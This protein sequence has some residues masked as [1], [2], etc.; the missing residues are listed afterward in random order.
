[1][2]A[3]LNSIPPSIWVAIIGLIAAV[4][5]TYLGRKPREADA[6]E[7]LV[8]GAMQL[9]DE[10]KEIVDRLVIEEAKSERRE[11][12]LAARVSSLEH[13]ERENQ[14]W[15]KALEQMHEK[16]QEEHRILQVNYDDLLQR[17]SKLQQ[18]VEG[19]SP[20]LTAGKDD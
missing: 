7:K 18:Q 13:N 5:G 10:Y 6:A 11:R 16:L 19:S 1:M 9:N 14:Q 4:V 20:Q 3:W 17:H 15:I 2:M 12:K 8:A